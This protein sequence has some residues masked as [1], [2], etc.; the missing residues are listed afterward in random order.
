MS[1]GVVTLRSFDTA[2]LPRLRSWLEESHVRAWWGEQSPAFLAD[3]AEELAAGGPSAYR[4]AELDGR[5]VGFLF[6]YPIH[7]YVEY[8][9]E[10]TQA[11]LEVPP[12]AWSMDYLVGEPTVLGHGVAAAMVRVAADELWASEPTA[13]CI[14]VPVHADNEPS[15]RALARAGFSRLPGVFEMEPDVATHDRRHVVSQLLR[16]WAAWLPWAGPGCAEAAL[17]PGCRSVLGLPDGDVRG[18]IAG[19]RGPGPVGPAVP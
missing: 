17:M 11:G 3:L 14:I 19:E 13:T 4:M 7:A 15:W 10:L 5:T 16:P 12:G 18:R 8:V 9:V 2:D 6:R 1:T